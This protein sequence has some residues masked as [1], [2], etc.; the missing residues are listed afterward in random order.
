MIHH[1][2]YLIP[3]ALALTAGLILGALQTSDYTSGLIM[4]LFITFGY[5]AG[6]IS[7]T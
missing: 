7:R 1:R 6:F 5:V 4:G 2:H 3:A